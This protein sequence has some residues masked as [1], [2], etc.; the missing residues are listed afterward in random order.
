MPYTLLLVE[1]AD[2]VAT[3]TINRPDKLNALNDVVIGEL[4]ACFR[5]LAD[6]PAV[7]A[8]I[9]TGAGR[10]F[11]A[12]ADIAA[13]ATRD[14]TQLAELS[15]RGGA[16]F[17]RIEQM[18]KPV[19]AAING[20]AFGGG[21]EL[22]LSCHLRVVAD[23]AKLGVPEVKLGLI[24][25]YG[26]TQRLARLLGRGRALQL[27]LTGDPIDGAEA[28]RLG[29]A[30]QVVAADALLAAARTMAAAILKNG[31]LAVAAALDVVDRGL[32]LPLDAALEL[33]S[34]RF[35][36]LADTADMREGTSA[37]L[38]KRPAV[39]RGV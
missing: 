39:F 30:N 33:E 13:I 10:A 19:I 7:G 1:T 5:A 26:A 37:F 3:V 31:P 16:V 6:D 17:R 29:I 18:A 35:G 15:R 4:D 28:Y 27:I 2:R 34:Q 11:A 22:A 12:G 36:A 8:I 20:F 24:P 14:A 38:E 21:C 23:S 32:D 9:L 25:G